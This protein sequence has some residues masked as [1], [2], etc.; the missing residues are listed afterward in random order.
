MLINP[1]RVLSS[2]D[3]FIFV[4][5]QQSEMSY[6]EKNRSMFQHLFAVTQ[7]RAVKTV[8]A[9]TQSSATDQVPLL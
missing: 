6:G 8:T 3:Y 4:L 5:A 7:L 2:F 9:Y 1:E